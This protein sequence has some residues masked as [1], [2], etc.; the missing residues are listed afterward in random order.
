MSTQCKTS[1][2]WSTPSDHAAVML[3]LRLATKLV[4]R[5][6]KSNDMAKKKQATKL[7]WKLLKNKVIW[8]NYNAAIKSNL[9]KNAVTDN[10]DTI[11]TTQSNY[12]DCMDAILQATADT[13]QKEGRVSK[14]W[15]KTSET[16]ILKKAIRL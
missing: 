9:E 10:T 5:K 12:T 11:K 3:V 1:R 7:N 15:F 14:D 13:I 8:A 2:R 4:R 16:I 6:A